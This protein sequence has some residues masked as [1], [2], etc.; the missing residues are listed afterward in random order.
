MPRKKPEPAH[1][2]EDSFTRAETA[3]VENRCPKINRK[4][5]E[6]SDVV[7]ASKT[8]AYREVLLGCVLMRIV[9]RSVDI[10]LPYVDQGEH[11]FSGRSLDEQVVNPFLH[12]KGIPSSKGPYL[13]VFRRQVK[14]DGAT[15]A[16]LKD[17]QGYDAFLKLIEIV[18]NENGRRSLV[19]ILDYLLYRFVLLREEAQIEVIQ[20]ERIS[21]SQYKNL[22]A[23]LLARPSGGFFPV[24]V[25]VGMIETI[26]HCFSLRWE[27]QFQDINVSDRA[28]GVAGDIT[29][30]EQGN[31]LMTIEVT[32]RP[33]DVPRVRATFKDKIAPRSLSEYVFL[34]H[35]ERVGDEARHQAERYFAQGFDVNFVDIRDWLVNTLVTVGAKGRRL[36]QQR[37]VC[38][39]SG[40][41]VHKALKVAWN[42]EIGHL[43]S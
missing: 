3:F 22:I 30:K 26:V 41:R 38:H 11:A 37:V 29:I 2:L 4:A 10:R 16:G 35:M 9:D 40:D 19:A 21:L 8:Q 18:E 20:L 42:E 24:I 7:F 5:K 13:S 39:L 43:T 23:G 6:A 25:V 31:V 14:F 12:E 33:V 27:V 28:S 17:K 34:V 15:R 36:F 1:I 32:E